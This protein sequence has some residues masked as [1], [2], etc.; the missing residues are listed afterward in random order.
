MSARV[1]TT[2]RTEAS[3]PPGVISNSGQA[4]IIGQALRGPAVP[5]QVFGLA[6]YRAIFGDRTGAADMF[7]VV[8]TAFKEGLGSAWILRAVGPSAVKATIGLDTNK[9]TVTAKQFGAFANTWTA[10]YTSSSKTLT[11]VKGS[12]TVTYTGTDAATLQAAAAVDP[13]VTVTVSA[14]PSSNVTATALAGGTDDYAN[15]VAATTLALLD[16]D[17]GDGAV[18]WAGKRFGDVGAALQTHCASAGRLGI[19]TLASGTTQAQAVSALASASGDNLVC[20][21]PHVKVRSGGSTLTVEPSGLALGARARA[22]GQEGAW[23]SPIR[24]IYGTAQY[25]TGV[26]IE[27]TASEWQTLN[28]GSVS[29]VRSVNGVPRVYGWRLLSASVST[30]RGGQFCDTLNRV[31]VGCD[32]VAERYVGVTV[33]GKGRRLAEFAGDLTGFLA[34]MGGAFFAGA[35]DPGYVVDVGPGVNSTASLAAGNLYASVGVRHC[36][37]PQLRLF[38]HAWIIPLQ[39]HFSE[40]DRGVADRA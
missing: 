13:D 34:S 33:D 40:L 8:Q 10:A 23:A 1:T 30:L 22:H 11:I 19:T 29:V 25:V 28:A 38:P 20:L 36:I 17:L 16:P 14:L 37:G 26:E 3:S 39:N 5:T 35:N 12:T 9:I 2:V 15:V 4:F 18:V 24:D 21:W 32:A 7:D 27:T 31:K 6:D